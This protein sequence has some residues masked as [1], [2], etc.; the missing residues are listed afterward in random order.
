MPVRMRHRQLIRNVTR[1]SYAAQNPP[2]TA[3][4]RKVDR[5]PAKGVH[6]DPIDTL[7]G[8]FQ[9]RNPLLDRENSIFLGIIEHT[10]NQP[11]DEIHRSTDNIDVTECHGIEAAW[12]SHDVSIEI[13]HGASRKITRAL[14]IL[15]RVL[16]G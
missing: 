15:A 6:R 9:K 13:R 1:R 16:W 3:I 2:R 11:T 10:N 14:P 5:E 12:K 4:T 7:S 8:T